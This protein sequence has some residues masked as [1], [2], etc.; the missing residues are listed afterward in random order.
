VSLILISGEDGA[1]GLD[2]AEGLDWSGEGLNWGGDG[3]LGD[4]TGDNGVD[5]FTDW[6]DLLLDATEWSDDLTDLLDDWLGD[7]VTE[8]V[9]LI[10]GGGL[11]SGTGGTLVSLLD[12]QLGRGRLE[13]HVHWD[14]SGIDLD[15]DW[16]VRRNQKKWLK[17]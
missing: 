5:L 3:T 12:I 8:N 2:G 13:Q 15:G 7:R 17:Y 16:A 11:L 10:L 6:L 9:S 14:W 4:T 1:S